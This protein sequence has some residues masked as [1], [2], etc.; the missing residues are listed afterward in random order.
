MPYRPAVSDSGGG[1][2]VEVFNP[3]KMFDYLAAGRAIISS[4]LPVLHE[5]LN[6]ENALFARADDSSDWIHKLGLLVQDAELR[7]R[8]AAQAAADAPQY[9]WHVRAER[10]LS[11]TGLLE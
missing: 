11:V 9:D 4:D 7:S 1:N 10:A 2:I 8:L 6:Q 3:M 5:I